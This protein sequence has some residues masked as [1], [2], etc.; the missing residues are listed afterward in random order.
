MNK[1]NKGHTLIELMIVIILVGLLGMWSITTFR[2]TLYGMQK[3]QRDLPIQRDLKKAVQSLQKDLFSA[4]RG[5]LGSL[6]DGGFEKLAISKTVINVFQG[7]WNYTSRTTDPFKPRKNG[8]AAINYKNSEVRSGLHSL[9]IWHNGDEL[10][11][12][13]PPLDLTPNTTYTLSGWVRSDGI[14]TAEIQ[15]VDD[16]GME[17][18][19]SI[20]SFN[21]Q[22][23]QVTQQFSLPAVVDPYFIRLV[24]PSVGIS[25]DPPSPLRVFFDD[26]SFSPDV[27]VVTPGSAQ[28]FEFDIFNDEGLREHHRYVLTP[29]GNSGKLVRQLFNY[30]PLFNNWVG[31]WSVSSINQIQFRWAPAEMSADPQEP[32]GSDRVMLVDIQARSPRWSQDGKEP[33]I[34]FTTKVFSPVP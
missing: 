1:K 24:A 9:E 11:V 15:M 17:I 2:N 20:G 29:D 14:N 3:M 21:T 4:S 31:E 27:L 8:W 22:W 16:S 28:S 19:P 5:S 10:F 26:I 23:V 13:S 32:R 12:Q 7:Q 25:E 33:Q 6:F 18:V 34:N 30:D